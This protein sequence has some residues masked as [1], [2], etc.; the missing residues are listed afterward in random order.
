MPLYYHNK[1]IYEADPYRDMTIS[2]GAL[3]I[4]FDLIHDGE[5]DD[6]LY[7]IRYQLNDFYLT[8]LRI[9]AAPTAAMNV[10]RILIF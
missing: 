9:K 5:D 7:K 6:L 10:P 3:Y 8:K 1:E 4:H 2:G